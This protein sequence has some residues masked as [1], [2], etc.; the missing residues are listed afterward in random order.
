MTTTSPT[1]TTPAITP[2][3]PLTQALE[4]ARA[5]DPVV[6]AVRPFGNWFASEPTRRDLLQGAWLGHALHPLMT[7]APIGLF[8]SAL[9]LD[10]L[11]GTSARPAA[12]RLI[13][14]GVLS[15][16]PTFWTGWA[17]WAELG[18]RDQRVGV[19]HAVAN[20]TAAFG[21]LASWRARRRGQHLKGV[22]LGFA[23]AGLLTVGG[24]LGGHLVS[25]RKASTR[26][27]AFDD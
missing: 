24:Y 3:V 4:Q 19:V 23:S 7:D 15:S 9:T 5:L 2:A 14:L 17:E 12:R 16:V 8:A 1:A 18:Q 25:A 10:V 27:P 6:S 13:G 20:G 22:A 26:H 11:G 21:F